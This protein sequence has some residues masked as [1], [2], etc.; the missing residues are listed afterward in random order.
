MGDVAISASTIPMVQ[1]SHGGVSLPVLGLGMGPN[2]RVPDEVTKVAALEAIEV[3]YRHFDTA[4]IY[5]TEKGLGEAISEALERGLIKSREDIFVTSKLWCSDAHPHLVVP[6]LKR[7]LE[8]LKL[9]Y[10]DLYMIHWPVSGKPMP[11]AYPLKVEDF[12]PFDLKGV[13][14]AME[15]CQKLGLAK[16]IGVCNF[17][18]KKLEQLLAIATIPPAVNQVEI[19]PKWQQKELIK[20]C[21]T[22]GILVMAHSPLGGP[23]EG[24]KL[25][26]ESCV[27]QEIAKAKGKTVAQI[28]LR[29]GYEQ[30]IAIVVNSYV[31]EWMIENLQ[32]FGWELSTEDH[33]KIGKIPQGRTLTG[34]DYLS[35]IGPYR[36]FEELWDG[37][38]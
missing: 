7:S 21:K 19:N 33:E 8:A 25:V 9:E 14:S 15:E 35:P 13:W 27:L 36:T 5:L 34:W 23:L 6:A 28:A 1:L 17:T 37:D 26:M 29:W 2:P 18:R 16:A 10:L 22:K 11:P 20:F 3:G 30:G 31:K 4:P 38:L 24:H 32:I 12:L